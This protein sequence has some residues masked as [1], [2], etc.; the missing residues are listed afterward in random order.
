MT[1][2]QTARAAAILAD[3]RW[4]DGFGL[5][6][7][8]DVDST[9]AEA[10]RIAIEGRTD[11]LW[12][13]AEQQLAGRARRG[14][15][16]VSEPG[17][18]YASLLLPIKEDVQSTGTLPLVAALAVHRAIAH[19]LPYAGRRLRLKWPN[20]VLIDGA[21]VNGILLEAANGP[22]GQSIIIG[23][24]IN[25]RHHPDNPAY[26]ATHLGAEGADVAA[27]T[28]M[29]YL[30]AE[31]SEALRLWDGGHGFGA[32]RQLWM[33]RAQGIGKPIRVNLE[34]E[35]LTGLF[36]GLDSDGYLMLERPDGRL[37]RI[38]A[39]DLFFSNEI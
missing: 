32:I 21:K 22:S 2:P 38:S 20:D 30:A 14:R 39:G 13:M 36:A 6:A 23:C 4:P 10:R 5:V 9:N 1:H 27:A 16:W 34:Q 11:P 29:P 37:T 17:N 18:L 33:D 19:F 12:I 24:G 26:P 15:S 25:C 28:L 7:L 8:G 31:M 35:T 3:P